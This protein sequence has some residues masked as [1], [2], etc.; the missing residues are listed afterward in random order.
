MNGLFAFCFFGEI[1]TPLEIGG[2]CLI[3]GVVP[4]IT[5]IKAWRKVKEEKKENKVEGLGKDEEIVQKHIGEEDQHDI[6]QKTNAVGRG[7]SARTTR[8]STKQD[9]IT[10]LLA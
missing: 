9:E 8:Y 1:M 7:R 4:I 2:A 6:R 5:A 10:P 3:G